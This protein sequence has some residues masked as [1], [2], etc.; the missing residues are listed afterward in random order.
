[1]SWR[2]RTPRSDTQAKTYLKMQKIDL[3]VGGR[4]WRWG[5]RRRR[6]PIGWRVSMMWACPPSAEGH[7]SP[8]GWALPTKCM[9]VLL[10]IKA[11]GSAHPTFSGSRSGSF[12][13]LNH[14]FQT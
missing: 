5:H 14:G 2:E 7:L 3:R 11:V 13:G 4:V 1:M 6:L 10:Q 12:G 9:S 8:V